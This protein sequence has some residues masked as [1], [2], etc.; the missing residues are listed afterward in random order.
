MYG[1]KVK[2]RFLFISSIL[3]ILSLSAFLILESL[4]DNVVYFQSPTE[5]KNLVEID[6]NKIRVGG[7][8]KKKSILIEEKELK[9]IV[10]DYKKEINVV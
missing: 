6:K 9:F 3:F 1:R 2:L 4:K 5:I 8:V 10:T 7:M